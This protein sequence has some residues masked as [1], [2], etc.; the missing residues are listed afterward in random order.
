M[1]Y[2]GYSM[3]ERAAAAY[4]EG[5]RPLTK[6]TND[7]LRENGINATQTVV[8]DLIKVGQI[9]TTEWHHTG[10][11]YNR[12]EFFRPEAIRE[13]VN[14]LSPEEISAAR[15]KAAQLRKQE[16]AEVVHEHCWVEWLQW[17][18]GSRQPWERFESGAR[19]VVKGKFATVT[20][21]S[22]QTF[23]KKLDANGFSFTPST[24]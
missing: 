24:S 1:G 21:K 13:V 22:G 4:D 7:W 18:K 8:R 23:R 11:K 12:T 19:V 15:S 10:S 2:I 20:L 6:I 17:T 9:Y 14:N 16:R 5:A 3:S